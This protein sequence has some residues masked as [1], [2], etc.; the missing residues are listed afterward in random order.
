MATNCPLAAVFWNHGRWADLSN[1]LPVLDNGWRRFAG[2]Q[3]FLSAARVPMS[4]ETKSLPVPAQVAADRNV[5]APSRCCTTPCRSIQSRC[6]FG[7]AQH[8]LRDS[9]GAFG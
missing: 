8:A 9:A 4:L 5:R 3:T 6:A 1:R 7:T 2:A